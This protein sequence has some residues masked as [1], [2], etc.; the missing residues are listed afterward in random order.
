MEF[1]V[2]C[3]QEYIT[4]DNELVFEEGNNYTLQIDEDAE[5]RVMY[6]KEEGTLFLSGSLERHFEQYMY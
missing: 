6:N 1:V 3:I 4:E 2:R 5:A